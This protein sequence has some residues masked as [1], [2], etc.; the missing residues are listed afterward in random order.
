M[1]TTSPKT[2]VAPF[3]TEDPQKREEPAPIQ[4]AR[5]VV[6][7]WFVFSIGFLGLGVVFFF[8]TPNVPREARYVLGLPFFLWSAGQLG[9]VVACMRR[10]DGNIERLSQFAAL[11]T[12]VFALMTLAVAPFSLDALRSMSMW[13][14]RTMF[15]YGLIPLCALASF[16]SWRALSRAS[17]DGLLRKQKDIRSFNTM[18]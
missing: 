18:R 13:S 12:I 14:L 5:R 11:Y 15:L 9:A 17:A 8:F 7:F 2:S 6:R 4:A 3:G 16:F 10:P 1:S